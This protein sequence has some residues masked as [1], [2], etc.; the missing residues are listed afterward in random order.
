[1]TVAYFIFGGFLAL[2]LVLGAIAVSADHWANGFGLMVAA[3][4]AGVIGAVGMAGTALVH[5]ILWL[6]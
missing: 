5:L 2:M 3:A 1:M 6:L 4:W